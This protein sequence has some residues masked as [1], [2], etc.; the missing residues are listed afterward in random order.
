MLG[1]ECLFPLPESFQLQHLPTPM[2]HCLQVCTVA[3]LNSAP[4]AASGPKIHAPTPAMCRLFP[5]REKLGTMAMLGP[6]CLFPLPESF[7]L[8]HLPTPMGHF[9]KYVPMLSSTAPQRRRLARKIV[10]PTPAMC[11]LFSRPAK[12]VRHHGLVRSLMGFSSFI[13]PSIP[14]PASP[15]QLPET[16][17]ANKSPIQ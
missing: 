10:A 17:S 2:G 7:Q 8:Q 9:R 12:T 6:E 3:L 4:A 5:P 14:P 11:R 16:K 15:W 13:Q 1:S